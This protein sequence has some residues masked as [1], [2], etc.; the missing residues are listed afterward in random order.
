MTL[1][2]LLLFIPACFALNMAPGPN[3]L[4]SMANA[5]RY[6]KHVA[7]CISLRSVARPRGCLAS[8]SLPRAT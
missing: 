5:K 6:G 3:N 7:G 2:T 1:M 8:R 4:L